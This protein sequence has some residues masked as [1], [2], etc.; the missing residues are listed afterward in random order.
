MYVAVQ[1][2]FAV[3]KGPHSLASSTKTFCEFFFAKL[4]DYCATMDQKKVTF[5]SFFTLSVLHI[6]V[7]N[8]HVYHTVIS[9]F[10]CQNIFIWKSTTKF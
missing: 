2:W 1:L 5:V 6:L 3:L 4:D 8:V 10:C 9:I 7:M